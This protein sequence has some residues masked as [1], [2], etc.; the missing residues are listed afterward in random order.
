MLDPKTIEDLKAKHGELRK[1][2]VGGEVFA[3][4][5][6]SRAEWRRFEEARVDETKRGAARE[7]LVRHCVVYPDAAGLEAI[8]DRKPALLIVLTEKASELAGLVGKVED[9]KL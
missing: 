2:T 9:E 5:G 8:L 1:I 7:N 6:P 4:R 3:M